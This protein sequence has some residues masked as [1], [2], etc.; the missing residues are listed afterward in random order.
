VTVLQSPEP[1]LILASASTARRAVLTAAGLAFE[2]QPA[3]IDEAA[4]KQGALAEGVS[5]DETALL[6]AELK[7]E[8]VARRAPG[9][10]VIGAD[11]ILVCGDRRFDKP[12]NLDDA[13]TH[14]LAL[15][16][17]AHKLVTAIVCLRDGARIWH[18]VA[19]PRLVMRGFSDRFLD[20]YLAAEGDALLSS[21]GAYRL[22]GLGV[23]LFDRIEGEHAAILG[24][25]LLP[26]LG[27]LRQHGVVMD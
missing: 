19:R 8:R 23:H 25:P 11:Q 26:L 5:A 16:G 13:R 3:H 12:A 22:E 18:H 4:V 15:R 2:T 7:A 20:A 1:L 27:F 24:L 17:Q 6:L 14:L 21:V 9:A 10:L